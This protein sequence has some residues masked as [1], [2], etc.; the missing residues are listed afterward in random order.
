MCTL[1]SL[2]LLKNL[3]NRVFPRVRLSSFTD[4]KLL[5]D[6]LMSILLSPPFQALSMQSRGSVLAIVLDSMYALE[7]TFINW[8]HPRIISV[9][10]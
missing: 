2:P 10:T 9:C 5:P 7:V 4:G 8:K 6:G 3:T 1:P